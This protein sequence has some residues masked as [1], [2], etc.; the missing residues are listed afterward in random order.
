MIT[1]YFLVF[2]SPCS[3]AWRT[4]LQGSR[5]DPMWGWSDPS[6]I[7]IVK[8]PLLSARYITNWLLQ[9]ITT[10]YFECHSHTHI[11]GQVFSTF[12]NKYIMS[13]SLVYAATW[14]TIRRGFSMKNKIVC[15]N[16]CLTFTS[17]QEKPTWL[18]EKPTWLQENPLDCNRNPLDC[19]RNPLDCKRNPLDCK[20]N[21]LDWWN[22]ALHQL[23][24]E[25]RDR[26]MSYILTRNR[27]IIFDDRLNGSSERVEKI[28]QK[29]L[30]IR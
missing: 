27:V 1:Y 3:G 9:Y 2:S 24:S 23:H 13:R 26:I 14:A 21:P 8:H 25:W 30:N 16:W 6:R 22:S 7:E 19:K 10:L 18:Q 15:L 11:F 29:F 5:P 28:T 17:L 12:R 4:S 20:R